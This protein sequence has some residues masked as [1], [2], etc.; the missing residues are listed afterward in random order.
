MANKSY[1][2]IYVV[3]TIILFTI[4]IFYGYSSNPNLSNY[5]SDNINLESG[6]YIRLVFVGSST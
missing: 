6:K 1:F 5:S 3:A 4:G 2:F